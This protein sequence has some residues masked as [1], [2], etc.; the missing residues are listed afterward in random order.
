MDSANA[1]FTGYMRVIKK[2]VVL[3]FNWK[4]NPDSFNEDS[5]AK[6]SLYYE[7]YMALKKI[8]CQINVNFFSS[9]NLRIHKK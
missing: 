8:L 9:I 2:V 5:R 7:K 4:V 3:Y 6:V 1:C